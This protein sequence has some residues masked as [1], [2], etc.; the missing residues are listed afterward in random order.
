MIGHRKLNEN[1]SV[2]AGHR[3]ANNSSASSACA[4][5]GDSTRWPGRERILRVAPGAASFSDAG[6]SF[7]TSLWSWVSN[8]SPPAWTCF[9]KS[10][11]RSANSW[12]SAT[13]LIVQKISAM[14]LGVEP[15]FRGGGQFGVAS[16]LQ[17]RLRPCEGDPS[18][19]SSTASQTSTEEEIWGRSGMR[20]YRTNGGAPFTGRIVCSR[21]RKEADL[22]NR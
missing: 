9:T 18:G 15:R 3:E 17:G 16:Q 22:E 5:T 19:T 12:T 21:R 7:A 1:I 2:Q 10:A 6:T 13:V 4:T 20:P 14:R 8:T 11:S